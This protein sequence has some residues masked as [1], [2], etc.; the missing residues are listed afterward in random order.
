VGLGSR[1][2][3]FGSET[4]LSPVDWLSSGRVGTLSLGVIIEGSVEFARFLP[5]EFRHSLV[6]KLDSLFYL[7]LDVVGNFVVTASDVSNGAHLSVWLV[8]G[9]IE[10]AEVEFLALVPR[11]GLDK[12][13]R[14]ICPISHP[15]LHNAL[16]QPEC[17][18]C[19]PFAVDQRKCQVI[20]DEVLAVRLVIETLPRLAPTQAVQAEDNVAGRSR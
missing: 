5:S 11:F 20:K 14:D 18:I 4:Q 7:S 2:D 6:E 9:L 1:G 10:L 15:A 16:H 17:L 8:F 13:L 12:L 3:I 19:A